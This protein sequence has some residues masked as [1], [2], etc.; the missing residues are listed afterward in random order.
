MKVKGK[1]SPTDTWM[2]PCL[3]SMSLQSFPCTAST[4]G[5]CEEVWLM[6]AQEVEANVDRN[7]HPGLDPFQGPAHWNCPTVSL[8]SPPARAGVT[9][10]VWASLFTAL[11]SRLGAHVGKALSAPCPLGL[12]QWEWGA[13]PSW[14]ARVTHMCSFQFEIL[15]Q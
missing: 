9:P 12:A 11:L 15:Q 6:L 2:Q 3:L 4:A 1:A 5:V 7:Q 10:E 8:T 13:S 14:P